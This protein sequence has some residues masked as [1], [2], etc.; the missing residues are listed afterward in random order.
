M[1]GT[2][3]SPSQLMKNKNMKTTLPTSYN[4]LLPKFNNDV[5]RETNKLKQ[6]NEQNYNMNTKKNTAFML[7]KMFS[8]KRHHSIIS[9]QRV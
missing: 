7:I 6:R 4:Y 8:L 9:G 3:F 5:V 2:H 1:Q